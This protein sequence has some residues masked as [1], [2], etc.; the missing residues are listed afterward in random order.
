MM[1]K[2]T[3]LMAVVF[4]LVVLLVGTSSVFAQEPCADVQPESCVICHTGAGADHQA[5]YDELYQD[6]VIQVTDMAYE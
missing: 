2:R 5:S 1:Q 6:G 3:R 4:T